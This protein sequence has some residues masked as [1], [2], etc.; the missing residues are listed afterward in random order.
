MYP[1]NHS[2]FH[3]LNFTLIHHLHFL[4]ITSSTC[5]KPSVHPSTHLDFH[6]NLASTRHEFN[7]QQFID[8]PW[9]SHPSTA[10]LTFYAN[11]SSTFPS[12]HNHKLVYKLVSSSSTSLEIHVLSST[13]PELYVFPYT[14]P[15]YHHTNVTSVCLNF[16]S[17]HLPSVLLLTA[18]IFHVSSLPSVTNQQGKL[19]T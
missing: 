15:E 13:C 3:K 19:E 8:T 9:I 11:P 5:H 14:C 10:C 16:A 18:V 4:Y 6:T 2:E 12:F 1:S 7:T 17:L